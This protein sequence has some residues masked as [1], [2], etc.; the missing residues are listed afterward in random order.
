MI[1]LSSPRPHPISTPQPP[2]PARRI[3][4][5]ATRLL[6][7]VR[8]FAAGKNGEYIF[9]CPLDKQFFGFLGID[10]DAFL[11]EAKKGGSDTEMLAW[12]NAQTK[13]TPLEAAEWSA[14]MEKAQPGLGRRPRQ[15]QRLDHKARSRPRGYPDPVRPPR[16]RRLRH[17]RRKGLKPRRSQPRFAGRGRVSLQSGGTKR[18]SRS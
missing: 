9:P 2:C 17:L 13:R 15:F 10:P 1:N 5:S 12:V 8:A 3:R 11:A 16:S 18:K 6:D 14:W 4:P 7:K